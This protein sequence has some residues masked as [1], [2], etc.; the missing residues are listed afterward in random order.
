MSYQTVIP[1]LKLKSGLH[2][3][4][5]IA[6]HACDHVLKMALKLSIYRLQVYLMK[7]EYPR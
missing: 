5:T 2:T 7:Y 1:D 6:K 4:V 3:V